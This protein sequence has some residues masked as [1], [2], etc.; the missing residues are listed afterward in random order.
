RVPQARDT[1]RAGI[2]KSDVRQAAR[3]PLRATLFSVV[4]P[5]RAIQV[6]RGA[7]QREVGERLGEVAQG[8]AAGTDLFS[9]EAD[10]VGVAV[11]AL[12]ELARVV[13][14][15][16]LG[17]AG[18]GIGLHAPE[19]AEVEG[20]LS[21][22]VDAVLRGLGVIAVDEAVVAQSSLAGGSADG[23]QRGEHPRIVV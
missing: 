8:L 23:L 6:H 17:S 19:G 21:L 22:R 4:T 7:D 20:A 14:E 12:E 2:S 3:R 18:A 1:A 13:Q 5:Q 11:H 16:G 10:V 9:V 15:A